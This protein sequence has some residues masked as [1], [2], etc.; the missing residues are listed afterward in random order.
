LG[1]PRGSNAPWPQFALGSKQSS[2]ASESDGRVC[3]GS[4][5]SPV[6]PT[7]GVLQFLRRYTASRPVSSSARASSSGRVRRTNDQGG[8]GLAR[9]PATALP[10]VN[11]SAYGIITIL[12]SCAQRVHIISRCSFSPELPASTFAL[13]GRLNT[14]PKLYHFF[15]FRVPGRSVREFSILAPAWWGFVR[16][17]GPLIRS[18]SS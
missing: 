10:P 17:S 8:T 15:Y 1:S 4:Q 18:G 5:L 12:R 3:L 7:R 14:S 9:G 16:S 13:F 11:V 2:R 6:D